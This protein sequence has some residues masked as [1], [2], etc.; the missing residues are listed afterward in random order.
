MIDLKQ[1]GIDENNTS[2]NIKDLI[3]LANIEK[4]SI[5]SRVISFTDTIITI[6]GEFNNTYNNR[7]AVVGGEIVKIVSSNVIDNNT[8]FTVIRNQFNTKN[9]IYNNCHFRTVVI[10]NH[11]DD[12]ILQNWNFEDTLGNVTNSLFPVELS[13]GNI[14]IKSDLKLWSPHSIDQKYRVKPRKTIAYIFK[15][16]EEVNF[17]RFTTIVSKVRFN[18]RG[19]TEPNKIILE[20]KSKLAQWYDKDISLNKQLKGTNPKDFFKILFGLDEDEI[21][22]ANG[23]NDNSFLKLNNLHTKEYT[24]VSEILKAYCSNGIRFIFDAKE[25]LKI[26]SDFIVDNINSEKTVNYSLTD[27]ALSENEQ[28]IYNT[29]ST[30]VYQR[31]TLYNFEDLD[32]KYVKFF[33]KL[34]NAVNSSQFLK[35]SSSNEY[36]VNTI[37]I[38]NKDLHSSVQLKDYVMFKRTKEPY[39]EFQAMVIGIE[40]D[41]K[42]ILSPILKDKDYKLFYYGKNVYLYNILV[43]QNCFMDLYYGRQS[44]PIVFKYTRNRNNEEIDSSLNYPILPRVNGETK[45]ENITNITF[46]CAS[47]LKVGNYTGIIEEIDKIYGIW[48][49]SKLLYNMELEQFSNSKY[50]PIFVLS[51]KVNERLINGNIPVLNYTHFDNSDLVIEIKK[52]TDTNCD[53]I[54]NIT[55][56]KTVNKDIDLYVDKELSRI[57]NKIL[58]VSELSNYKLGD[59]LIAN[60]P[61]DLTPQEEIEYEEVIS[62]IRW[63]IVGK[64]TQRQEDG[65]FKNYIILDSPFA[66]RHTLDKVYEFTRFPNWS[67]VYLQELYFRGNP[68]IE[69]SQDVVGYSKTTNI[70]GDT[71]N[72]LYGEKK[73]EIDSK[74]LDKNSLKMLMG[75][76]LHNFQA[77]DV[78][79]TKW[80]LPISVFN[81][82]DIETLDIISVIDPIYTDLSQKLKWIVLSVSMK[83]NT[84]VVELKLLNINTKNTEPYKINVKDVLEYKPVEIPDY[85]HTG[86]EG[87]TDSNNDGTGG[88]D[89]DK[90]LGK[91]WLAEVDPKKFRA[92]VEKFE[93]NYIYFKD[94]N[95]E[96]VEQ[97]KGKLFPVD[98][99]GVTIKGETI[100]VQSDKEFRAFIKKRRV[101]DTQ[102]VTILPEDEVTFLV[103]TTYV[104]IDGT[105]YGRKMMMGDGD[106]YLSVDPITGVKVVGDFVVGENNKTPS[107][108]LW[109]SLQKNRTFQQPSQPMADGSYKLKEGDLWFDTDDQNHA[110]RY[111]GKV[112]ISARDGSIVS[113][114]N[115]IYLQPDEPVGSEGKPLLEG[116]TWYDTDNGN[117]PYVYKDGKWVNV[118][119]RTLEEAINEVKKQAEEST[120]KLI[121][122]AS[123][124]KLTPNEKKQVAKE[125]EQIK[126][127]YNKIEAEGKK[128]G[129]DTKYYKL[130]YDELLSYIP[131][132]IVNM[133]STSVIVR[134][135]FIN[136]FTDYYN[137]RQDLLNL[138]SSK[139]KELADKAQLDATTALGNS[140]IFYQNEKPT[141]GVKD[142]DLWFDTNDQNHPYIYKDGQ[143]VDARDTSILTDSGARVFYQPDEPIGTNEIPL[144]NGDIW[145][146]TDEGNI[147]YVYHNKQWIDIRDSRLIEAL[148]NA[149]VFFQNDPPVSNPQ[150]YKLKQGDIWYD[151]NDNNHVYVYNNGDW[152]SAQDKLINE[153]LQASKVFQQPNEPTTVMFNLKKGDLWYDTDDNN[154]LYIY[155]GTSWISGK[156]T[157]YLTEG[158]NRVYFQNSQPMNTEK[159]LLKNDMWIDTDDSNHP[160]VYN[161]NTWVSARDGSIL[162]AN[163]AIYF[164]DEEPISTEGKP[165]RDG[166]LWYDTNDGNRPYVY[167][168]DRWVDA[169]DKNINQANKEYIEKIVASLGKDLTTQIDGKIN[170]YNQE[171]DPSISWSIEDKQK[172]I[173]D[174]WYKPSEKITKRWNGNTWD[175]LDAKDTVAQ[176]L[177]QQKRRVFTNQPTTPYDAGDLWMTS[178]SS[179]G[180]LM[181][182]IRSRVSGDFVQSDWVKGTKYTDDTL[183]NEAQNNALNAQNSADEANK[184]LTDIASD[185]KLTP[186]EKNVTLKEWGIIVSEFTI[187][188]DQAR[189]FGVDYTNYQNKY[190]ELSNYITPLIRDINTTSDINGDEFRNK[191]KVY[192]DE[193]QR[194]LNNITDKAKEVA[195]NAVNIAQNALKNARIF[196]QP[197]EPVSSTSYQLKEND[198]WY[199]TDD[200]NHPYIYQ[201]NKWVSARDKAFELEGGIKVYFQA[202]QPP[203]TGVGAKAG[204]IWF[205]TAHNNTMYVLIDE[206][207]GG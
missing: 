2:I 24:T 98:E 162:N 61:N 147:Q 152:V 91:F 163:N 13:N 186:N 104:D 145:I 204:N 165:L 71:S 205:D 84:N 154:H 189:I 36:L 181:L 159:P 123:D 201:G 166:D 135:I 49:N 69:Y 164:Q 106:T 118:T 29:I 155:N 73:Y 48:D 169:S 60:K 109:Q 134:Q 122:I 149:R 138:I 79:T 68:V 74:Q 30:Q 171:P 197:N 12:I 131:P 116:D 40:N 103:T 83:S 173:G 28:M 39:L 54:I 99:F 175:N 206:G 136:N 192:Y 5:D 45:Y 44:L 56:T 110:Y 18:T 23:V 156:D 150:G 15:G 78:E 112:W 7:Y 114:K 180:D 27:I 66:K 77:T 199:D 31:Q 137:T 126:G 161:G 177:A 190:N 63:R 195:D 158:G 100:F 179:N 117:K 88:T 16:I 17:L 76:I 183:A 111:N 43:A 67:I 148:N 57:G 50:P 8:E 87:N 203:T 127:E 55:N 105:F 70:D 6:Q 124:D 65:T 1:Y 82:I 207:G 47:N 128:F 33:K 37:E 58:Q 95:G 72:E 59:I 96:E 176:A 19:K 38:Q 141:I 20:I 130:R 202:T 174:L 107:N 62:S 10:L 191:F 21:Y 64:E 133:E 92:R 139:A 188:V 97:Y 167:K 196:Y 178:I 85:S 200:N 4:K 22:Y 153:A 102:E 142:N 119:D 160:Y 9:D 143:W 115:T 3:A 81:G 125:W 51:N 157:S 129:V 146:D 46:G 101:Y 26:F 121:D 184:K 86:G 35:L 108:D 185:S 52:P 89:E 151:T 93:G 34:E 80:N 172:H 14:Q 42:V 94:F 193:R 75:Y 11:T 144:K 168:I 25:R 132:L 113:E 170:S 41:N 194:L 32:N 187:N 140:K 198:L 182:C 90:T 53:A 120:K